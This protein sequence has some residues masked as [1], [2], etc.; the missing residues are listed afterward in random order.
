[1][2]AGQT[3]F[4]RNLVWNNGA[5]TFNWNNTD[6]NWNFGLDAFNSH[7][8]DNAIFGAAGGAGGTLTLTQ[9]ITAGFLYFQ[10]SGYTIAGSSPNGLTLANVSAV[11]NDADAAI[12]APIVAGALNKWG[13]K[14]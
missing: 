8:P 1:M 10:T 5:G 4:P 3:I 11:T 13:A 7:R 6:L 2:R 9:P 12:S 14:C